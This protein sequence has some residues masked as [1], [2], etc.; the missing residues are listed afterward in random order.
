MANSELSFGLLSNKSYQGKKVSFDRVATILTNWTLPPPPITTAYLNT[1]HVWVTRLILKAGILLII[2][3]WA[4]LFESCLCSDSP[5]LLIWL[6]QISMRYSRRC[7]SWTSGSLHDSTKRC[8]QFSVMKISQC[9]FPLFLLL[10]D[11]YKFQQS[12]VLVLQAM[13]LWLNDLRCGMGVASRIIQHFFCTIHH[14][15]A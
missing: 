3:T 4:Y 7:S 15:L 8:L 5:L 6:I 13:M 11:L 1:C 12:E 14:N 2:R 9:F 10:V